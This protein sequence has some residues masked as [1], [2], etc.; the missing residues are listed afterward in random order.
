MPDMSSKRIAYFPLSV[1]FSARARQRYE[2]SLE[3]PHPSAAETLYYLRQAGSR[4]SPQ[5]GGGTRLNL[6]AQLNRALRAVGRQ[7][8]K[9]SPPAGQVT[10]ETLS[11]LLELFPPHD[12]LRGGDAA[13]YLAAT[14][15]EYHQALLELFL[16]ALH[17]TNPAAAEL[18][19]LFDDG[20]LQ[21]RCRYR[22]E[23]TRFDNRQLGAPGTGFAGQRLGNL[24]RAPIEAAP[25]SLADQL[26][27]VRLTWAELLPESIRQAIDSAFDGLAAEE[28]I[29]G[30]G[31]FEAPIPHYP[32]ATTAAADPEQFSPDR[33]WMPRTV[34]MAKS[35][36]V[37]LEQLS[38]QYNRSIQSL[39]DIPDA[40]LDRLSGQ[41]FTA[42]WLIGLWERSPASRQIKRI[43]G[44]PEAEASAYSLYDYRVATDLGGEPALQ[45]LNAR[46][47]E[48]GLRLACDVV[49]NHTGIVSRWMEEHPDWFIQLDYP[50]YPG[51]R[52]DGPDLSSRPD[53]SIQIENG[54]FDR[55]DAAV[56][57]RHCD[58]G[59]GR[60]RYIYHG[61]D[62]THTPWN[63]TAQLNFLLPEVREAMIQTILEVA[64][65][66]KVIRFDA[67][68][69]LARKHFQRLWFPLPGGGAG[70]PSR[71]EHWMAKEEFDR[72]FPVEFW[73]EVVDRVAAEVPDT[74]LLAEAFWLMESFFV[75]TLGMH[76]VYNSAFMHM[77]KN[78][79]NGK[80]Q[81]LLRNTLEFNP[82]ILKRFVNFM[83]NPDEASAADQFGKGDKYF[84]V[85][86]LLV[87]LP[88][89]PMFGHGQI[90]GYTEKYG[91]EYRRSYWN[92][93]VDTGFVAHHQS[94][95]FPLLHRR[96]L[97]SEA[98]YFEL[99]S[100]EGGQGINEDVFAFSNGDDRERVLV[101]YHNRSGEACGWIHHS[102][103]R[104]RPEKGGQD[105]PS[106]VSLAAALGLPDD[107]AGYCRFRDLHSGLQ[108][109]RPV[110]E[111][112]TRGLFLQLGGYRYRVFT[113]FGI[114]RDQDG[115][116]A[117]LCER[118]GDQPV[119]D[120]DLALRKLQ[121]EPL[122]SAY[123]TLLQ[124]ASTALPEGIPALRSAF[125]NLLEE[126]SLED[127]DNNRKAMTTELNRQLDTLQQLSDPPLSAARPRAEGDAPLARP[128]SLDNRIMGLFLLLRC[129]DKLSMQGTPELAE[130]GLQDPVLAD[131]AARQLSDS[132]RQLLAALLRWQEFFPQQLALPELLD[133]PAVQV[134]LQVNEHQGHWWLRAEKLTELVWGLF[135][136]KFLTEPPEAGEPPPQDDQVRL[137]QLLAA[138]EKSG[139]RLDRLRSFEN[140]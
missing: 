67:A 73:R 89:L 126:I 128:D 101:A 29:R 83:S 85:A 106:A 72:V 30:P 76:R 91:M 49:P 13:N 46:C 53:V 55:S 39:E 138:A 64:R 37:W 84:G 116:W 68:M 90:E 139:Y 111:L 5:A 87:T 69:T 20:E 4:L 134:L 57:F 92:E 8:F 56:V 34:L 50:P 109:L 130:G 27:F 120:L 79:D 110:A 44:N 19:P 133:D 1:A 17:N 123:E 100:L 80:Y 124:T 98:R 102:V 114:V 11:S 122:R 113:D 75:R 28:Q 93:A 118:L 52:F 135:L 137:Q 16:L 117:R 61:N 140:L 119:A 3:P 108:Y 35:A 78:E 62:G 88:G 58:L 115:R 132:D 43:M 33:D 105:A 41:G 129:L 65:T 31:S 60:V 86:V 131:I 112:R 26:A 77:L 36:Y 21:G 12:L 48:R 10:R 15:E 23:L 24:L 45:S 107:A 66:F 82:E 2:L 121:L 99:Y 96:H 59:S 47:R 74:L 18:R 22:E 95:I 97:F 14:S 32:V 25:H 54:Y 63:D 42:L 70:V 104:A 51:Y 7:F 125:A 71:A 94:Q 136:A 81:K 127:P 9:D 38:R 6:L 103:A 40:E